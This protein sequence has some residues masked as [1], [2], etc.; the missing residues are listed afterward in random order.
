MDPAALE[1]TLALIDRL[2]VSTALYRLGC[3]MERDAAKLSYEA[4]RG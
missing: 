3:N 1:K 2:T 4:M